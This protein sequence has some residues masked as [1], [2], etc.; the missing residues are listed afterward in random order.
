MVGR[1]GMMCYT[2]F[3]FFFPLP[4]LHQNKSATGQNWHPGPGGRTGCWS[5]RFGFCGRREGGWAVIDRI[6]DYTMPA[7]LFFS[8]PVY[9]SIPNSH[10]NPFYSKKKLCQSLLRLSLLFSQSVRKGVS[11]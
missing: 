1:L 3:S 5:L 10:A 7:L 6:R 8:L 4:F 2:L 11:P 9:L